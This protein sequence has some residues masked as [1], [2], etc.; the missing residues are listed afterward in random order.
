MCEVEQV[1]V[2]PGSIDLCQDGSCTGHA[3]LAEHTKP[4]MKYSWEYYGE[5]GH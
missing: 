2:G 3:T 5:S 4:G 1:L